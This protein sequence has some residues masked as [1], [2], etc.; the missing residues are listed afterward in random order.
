[1]K[2]TFL[3]LGFGMWACLQAWAQFPPPAGQPGTTAI[4]KDSLIFKSW[5]TSCEVVRG[6]INISD[7]NATYNDLNHA[8]YGVPE[9]AT[10]PPD[11]FVVS[12]GDG[13]TATLHFATPIGNGPGWDFAVFENSLSNDFLELAFVEVST[14]GIRFVRFPATSLVQ[15]TIQTPSFGNTDATKINNLAGKYRLFYGTPFD[16][17]ELKDSAGLNIQVITEVRI[18]D[19]V[20]C[21]QLP[22]V[23][24][25][26]YGHKMNDPWP[27]PF[28]T[29]GFDL[30][31]VGVI[32]YGDVSVGQD[33]ESVSLQVYPNPVGD[34]LTVVP[35]RSTEGVLSL[36][37]MEGIVLLQTAVHGP[38][39]VP[40]NDLAPGLYL[41]IVSYPDGSLETRKIIKK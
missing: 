23:T 2:R 7:T 4:Y 16:L 24:Y 34:L 3:F 1:M 22:F 35:A 26:A 33:H 28:N 13:G 40:V 30:D 21:I 29:G 20:G 6:Y 18:V 15:D 14:D 5:A 37:T 19:V 31:A 8:S 10:G 38:L 9:D 25:D 27:T 41:G 17:A 36:R 39:Q 32:S 11:E 12:L